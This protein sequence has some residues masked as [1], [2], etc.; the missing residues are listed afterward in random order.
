[1]G[2]HE[3]QTG[4]QR[5]QQP[6]DGAP[7]DQARSWQPVAADGGRETGHDDRGHHLVERQ[8]QQPGGVRHLS[9]AGEEGA[10]AQP[11]QHAVERAGRAVRGA[12]VN[13]RGQLV[14][15][16][17][18]DPPDAGE[19]G[20]DAQPDQGRGSLP[21]GQADRQRDECGSDGAH[22]RDHAHPPRGQA[23]VEEPGADPVAESGHQ[24]PRVVG[25]G[26]GAGVKER[27]QRRRR[28]PGEEGQEADG[29]GRAG[30]PGR[31][32]ADEVG[33][34]VG[35]CRGQGEEHGH[36]VSPV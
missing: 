9:Q 7:G 8:R 6:R 24:S 17:A 3:E 1:M 22:G 29:P 26:G 21:G 23:A 25:G 31:Q 13:V 35:R 36:R 11:G 20:S 12:G 28:T 5:A 27:D 34:A 19:S 16:R 15:G 18:G 10:E 14:L 2:R 30:T 33:E 32:A 4:R